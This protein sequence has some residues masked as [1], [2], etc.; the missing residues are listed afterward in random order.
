MK[1]KLENRPDLFNPLWINNTFGFC[2]SVGSNISSYLMTEY[3]SKADF[4]FNY[5][6]V[7]RAYTIIFSASIVLPLILSLILACMG[8]KFNVQNLGK[9]DK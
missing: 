8:L 4:N 3:A 1:L 5:D 9:I 6:L 7:I 2:L